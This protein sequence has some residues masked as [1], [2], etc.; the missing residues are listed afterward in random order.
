MNVEN[1]QKIIIIKRNEVMA[2]HQPE[3]TIRTNGLLLWFKTNHVL[4][5]TKC[6]LIKS[7]SFFKLNL[8]SKVVLNHQ[9]FK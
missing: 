4:I 2:F 9:K 6:L 5:S 7:I 1:I 8:I 3:T